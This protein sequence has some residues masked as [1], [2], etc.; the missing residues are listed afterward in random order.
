LLTLLSSI[1]VC[2]V[3]ETSRDF[4]SRLF[5]FTNALADTNVAQHVDVD[6]LKRVADA[7]AKGSEEA[8]RDSISRARFLIRRLEATIQ[9]LYDGGASLMLAAQAPIEASP[10]ISTGIGTLSDNIARAVEQMEGLY[11]IGH[12]QANL[13]VTGAQYDYAGSISWRLSR[14][15]I[16]TP[17]DSATLPPGPMIETRTPIAEDGEDFVDMEAAFSPSARPSAP[18]G[19][20]AD[21]DSPS[22]N[23]TNEL[24]VNGHRHSDSVASFTSHDAHSTTTIVADRQRLRSSSQSADLLDDEDGERPRIWRRY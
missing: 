15:S 13:F 18:N 19:S 2:L 12:E 5:I 6:G 3:R 1:E 7:N 20:H 11:A 22:Y 21:Q 10:L 17:F 16:M 14:S 9:A 4:L 8:Y 23:G 24:T